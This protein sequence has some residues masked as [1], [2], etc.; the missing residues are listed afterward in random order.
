MKENL[1]EGRETILELRIRAKPLIDGLL[2]AIV[3]IPPEKRRSIRT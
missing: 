1:L 2:C 3:E